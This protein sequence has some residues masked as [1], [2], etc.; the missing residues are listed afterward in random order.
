MSEVVDA[1][2]S[3]L[4]DFAALAALAALVACVVV[5]VVVAKLGTG[6]RAF[7]NSSTQLVRR[8]EQF[9]FGLP[10]PE[11]SEIQDPEPSRRPPSGAGK[12][13]PSRPREVC[14]DRRK[15]TA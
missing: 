6:R 7:W 11:S 14:G 10:L 15:M 9:V 13:Y 5:H 4:G 8:S 1:P 3:R 12:S 2:V